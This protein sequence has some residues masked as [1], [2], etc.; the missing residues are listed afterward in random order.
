MQRFFS[1]RS[2][3]WVLYCSI[4]WCK[5]LIVPA[6]ISRRRKDSL[7][8]CPQAVFPAA[9][10]TGFEPAI[11]AL[12]G[13]HVNR[14][15]TGPRAAQIYHTDRVTS[16]IGAWYLYT[17]QASVNRSLDCSR[18]LDAHFFLPRPKHRPR[19]GD[20]LL[21]ACKTNCLCY[22]HAKQD[23]R[24][25]S[26]PKM[27]FAICCRIAFPCLMK[28]IGLTLRSAARC[29]SHWPRAAYSCAWRA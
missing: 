28:K 21:P 20:L 14:Y 13:P 26:F 3:S 27:I 19:N 8:L 29:A 1:I 9:A 22:R 16:R 7:A 5:K 15:T 17:G 6:R 11:S 18:V 12:T 23:H 10:P 24:T 25:C 4:A 2:L